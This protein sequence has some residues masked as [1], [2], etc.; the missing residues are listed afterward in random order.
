MVDPV[1]TPL[2]AV[3]LLLPI[4]DACDRLYH[5]YKLTRS[6]GQD[7]DLTQLQLEQQYSRLELTSET[8]V[9]DLQELDRL[10]DINDVHHRL[11]ATVFRTLSSIKTQFELAHKLLQHY[12]KKGAAICRL[13]QLTSKTN[14]SP[15]RENHPSTQASEISG[16]T[17]S[18]TEDA[19][20]LTEEGP[21][22]SSTTDVQA[23]D[24]FS[25]A[26]AKPKVSKRD[27]VF[28]GFGFGKKHK[29][30]SETEIPLQSAPSIRHP[31]ATSLLHADSVN[32]A[33]QESTID[34]EQRSHRTNFFRKVRWVKEHRDMMH[35]IIKTLDSSNTYLE[36]ILVLKPTRHIDHLVEVPEENMTW[37]VEVRTVQRA[38]KGLHESLRRM[39]TSSD[40]HEPWYLSIQLMTEFGEYRNEIADNLSA[41]P[42]RKEAYYFSFQKQQSP[43]S[44][45]SY[46][47]AETMPSH[48][49]GQADTGSSDVPVDQS[50]WHLDQAQSLTRTVPIEGFKPWGTVW[51]EPRN[52]NTHWLYHAEG[53]QKMYIGDL[54]T[55]LRAEDSPA[56]FVSHQRVQLAALIAK[57]YLHL[58]QVRSSCAEIRPS[59]F[60]FFGEAEEEKQWDVDD[61]LIFRPCLEIGFGRK[62][63]NSNFGARSGVSQSQNWYIVGL[64]LL[65]YQIGCCL[66]LEYSQGTSELRKAQKIASADLHQLDVSVSAKF[67]EIV[68]AC[69]QYP[70][71]GAG[72]NAASES[73]F[74]EGVVSELFQLQ[75]ELQ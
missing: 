21:A 42:L 40:K 35:S 34:S 61:P 59:S 17:A 12:D 60:R 27:K 1:G 29:K 33:S 20:Q 49:S 65:L 41:L 45:A 23:T 75:A 31:A 16:T 3:A 43:E 18:V 19:S 66:V 62:R 56:R 74:V 64:G 69:L 8:R 52:E 11:T 2:A 39:N 44:K 73:R 55:L 30:A 13:H 36:N 50:A 4:Y 54:P 72:G 53:Q 5:G 37:L 25:P 58:S 28:G 68:Q 38:L 63:D 14:H 10:G 47:I 46:L 57:S 22:A 24:T 70:A 26:K 6:F 67:A 51:V 7:F 15:E 32:T 71:V 48:S 9:V